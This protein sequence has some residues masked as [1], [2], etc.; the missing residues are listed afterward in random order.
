M[1]GHA[2]R[3]TEINPD[4][5]VITFVRWHFADNLSLK[6]R[7]PLL[8]AGVLFRRVYDLDCLPYQGLG[9]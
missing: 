5:F 4:E 2:D 8:K 1:G 6:E 7:T 9:F 3:V